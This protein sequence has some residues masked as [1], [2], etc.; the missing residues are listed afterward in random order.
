MTILIVGNNITIL[1]EVS[2]RF[3]EIYPSAT[4]VAKT[5]PLMAGKYSYAHSVDVLITELSMKRM[6]G[7]QLIDFVHHEHPDTPAYL[8][9][10]ET[11]DVVETDGVTGIITY[12][13]EADALKNLLNQSGKI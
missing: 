6:T 3:R 7:I 4:V 12:P 8:M 10:N 5:D 9:V 11:D 2:A 1:K 13:F